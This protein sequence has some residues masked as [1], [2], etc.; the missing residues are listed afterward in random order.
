MS[1]PDPS[2]FIAEGASAAV[3]R[4]EP[5]RVL[6]LFHDGVDQSIITREY[7]MAQAIEATGLPV[8]RALGLGE[9]A[10]RQ[11]IIYSEVEGPNLL[12]YIW[13]HPHRVGWAM[14]AMARLQRQIHGQ[15][16]PLLRSRKAILTEDIEMAPVGERLRAVAIDRLDQLIE[17]DLLSHGDLH[18]ANLIVTPDGLAV[19]DWSKAARA[20]PAADVV[21]SEM[22]MR[23]GPG[24]AGGWWEGAVRD[25]VTAYYVRHY[26]KAAR[27]EAEALAAWRAL[28][29][30]AWLRHR[31]PARDPAFAAYLT[32]ALDSAGLPAIE[33]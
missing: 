18:P 20:A 8:P 23:F 29:A 28:V 16:V 7:A 17:G 32:R 10:G 9:V 21:R 2:T 5:G 14:R 3:Y 6:K 15:S 25:G 12:H 27:M 11:G 22:L 4:L 31:L 19:I 33:G 26:R 13:R 24:Q 1:L 30:L